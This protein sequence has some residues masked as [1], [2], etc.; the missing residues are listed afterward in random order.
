MTED[1]IVDTPEYPVPNHDTSTAMQDEEDTI[2][3]THAPSNL[4]PEAIGIPQPDAPGDGS[5]LPA[6]CRPCVDRGRYSFCDKLWPVCTRCVH[7]GTSDGCFHAYTNP[8]PLIAQP[9]PRHWQ[10]RIHP[11]PHSPSHS[12]RTH[13]LN[14]DRLGPPSADHIRRAMSAAPAMQIPPTRVGEPGRVPSGPRH[15]QSPLPLSITPRGVPRVRSPPRNRPPQNLD[16]VHRLN[17]DRVAFLQAELELTKREA[18]L[19]THL[20]RTFNVPYNSAR[21]SNISR[22]DRVP[23]LASHTT[24]HDTRQAGTDFISTSIYA[25]DFYAERKRPQ[26]IPGLVGNRE[27]ASI[28]DSVRRMFLG[29]NAWSTDVSLYY[30]TDEYASDPSKHA[31]LNDTVIINE[32]NQL[33]QRRAELPKADESVLNPNQF[34]R[35][36]QRLTGFLYAINHPDASAWDAHFKIMMKQP[37]F[38]SAF[39]KWRQYCGLVRRCALQQGIDPRILQSNILGEASMNYER[40]CLRADAHRF[41]QEA[42]EI[43][44]RTRTPDSSNSHSNYITID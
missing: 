6:R 35:A 41:A 26:I 15:S 11:V 24:G 38:F 28:P 4:V 9:Q 31:K 39:P 30:F 23:V 7:D 10:A 42:V 2:D 12:E 25:G 16:K 5:K 33:Q 17:L 1:H 44:Y 37:D 3:N 40:S 21:P 19:I 22:H 13:V 29:A 36:W 43:A 27:F 8:P 32:H 34:I 18:G 14:D 20:P